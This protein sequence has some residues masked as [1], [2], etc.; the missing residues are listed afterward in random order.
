MRLR[1]YPRRCGEHLTSPGQLPC[2]LGLPPQVRGA[3]KSGSPCQIKIRLTPAGAGSTNNMKARIT[4]W[5]A[6]PR[7]CGEHERRAT[8]KDQIMGLPP[9]VR[10]APP[11]GVLPWGRCGLTPAGA[12]S[13]VLTGSSGSCSW[14]YPRRCGEHTAYTLPAHT[15]VGLPPQVRGAPALRARISRS[16]GLTPAGAGSTENNHRRSSRP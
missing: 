2:P 15:Y 7:R 4:H 8:R 10:G 14:A 1:A 5:G 11:T 9:Q 12:G 13:T 16:T 3:P 6:Y